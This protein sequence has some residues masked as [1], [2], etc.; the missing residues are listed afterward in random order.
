[1]RTL[2]RIG[3]APYREISTRNGALF[4]KE[5]WVDKEDGLYAEKDAGYD[6]RQYAMDVADLEYEKLQTINNQIFPKTTTTIDLMIDGYLYYGIGLL[7]RLNVSRT[8]TSNIYN[9]NNG[10]PVAVKV[11]EI[12]SANMKVTLQCDNAKSISELEDIDDRYPDPEDF[13]DPATSRFVAQ[14]YDPA[15]DEDVE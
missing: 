3:E 6:Y 4:T 11:I 9:N 10:F 14:K 5:K 2:Y 13:Q 15:R 1:V 8:T 7:T 12:S